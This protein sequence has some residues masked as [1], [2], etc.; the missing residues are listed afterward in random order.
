ML[1]RTGNNAPIVPN[2][3]DRRQATAY[4]AFR[5]QFANGLP[6]GALA[7]DEAETLALLRW[8]RCNHSP[9][10]PRRPEFPFFALRFPAS[11]AY[12]LQ[13]PQLEG[14][15]VSVKDESTNPSRT[16]KSR[17]AWEVLLFHMNMLEQKL[18][19][20]IESVPGMSIIS[21][22]STA[23]ALADAF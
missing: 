9:N 2:W 10:N 12:Q 18:S 7:P 5:G 16:H 22:G 11:N 8:V 4:L 19:G 6:N 1:T 17:M 23:L 3:M 15:D 13:I 14:L 20:R 21:A